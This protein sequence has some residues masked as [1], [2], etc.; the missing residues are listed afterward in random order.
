[1]QAINETVKDT[2]HARNISQ[3]LDALKA[4]KKGDSSPK[5][6]Y[7]R[8]DMVRGIASKGADSG[9]AVS[10]EFYERYTKERR[11]RRS[12]GSRRASRG[13]DGGQSGT[14]TGQG[15]RGKPI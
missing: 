1:M 9:Q 13:T 2:A 4:I 14:T 10:P 12:R 11:K 5:Q 6:W 3:Q 7:D 15:R 8:L